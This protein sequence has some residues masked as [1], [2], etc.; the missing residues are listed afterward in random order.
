MQIKKIV[1]LLFS[2]QSWNFGLKDK[3]AVGN[4]VFGAIWAT[5]IVAIASALVLASG[6]V[7]VTSG[8]WSNVGLITQM[9]LFLFVAVG[10]EMFF[11]GFLYNV[12]HAV[13]TMS[14]AVFVN[15]VMYTLIQ[16]LNPNA[17]NSSSLEHIMIG[18]FN[19]FLIALFLNQA[20]IY[21]GSIWMPIGI[22]FLFNITQS[23]VFGFVNGGKAVESF[24]N[25]TYI[26]DSIL[27]G[28]RYGLEASIVWTPIMIISILYF[29]RFVHTKSMKL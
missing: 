11:R 7:E 26:S 5:I 2:K 16:L 23:T 28:G 17:L 12:I 9:L 19:I 20:R 27:N 4:F 3:N 14:T 25:V 13:S 22:H 24:F 6:S 10:E 15:S 29:N 18:L 1:G 21:S 8:S